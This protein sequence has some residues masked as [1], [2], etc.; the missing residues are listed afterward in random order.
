MRHMYTSNETVMISTETI[1]F[2]KKD[3]ALYHTSQ[4]DLIQQSLPHVYF[5]VI[6][7]QKKVDPLNKRCL[8]HIAIHIRSNVHALKIHDHRA[9]YYLE[10]C[11]VFSKTRHGG[12]YACQVGISLIAM[13]IPCFTTFY[14]W[15]P[16]NL[17]SQANVLFP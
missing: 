10:L 5:I 2:H 8:P 11:P 4:L 14:P 1:Y 13:I 7:Q 12:S 6:P 17:I 16:N 3:E 9:V 15:N